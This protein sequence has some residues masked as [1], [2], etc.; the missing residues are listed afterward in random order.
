MSIRMSIRMSTRLQLCC[1]CG[2]KAFCSQRILWDQLVQAWQLAPEEAAYIDRQQGTVCTA[3]GCNL[4]AQALAK[5]ILSTRSRQPRSFRHLL[6]SPSFWLVK[7]L[8]L[9]PV[10]PLSSHLRRLPRRTLASYPEVDMQHLP[11]ADQTFDLVLHA[12]TLEH[13]PEPLAA[14]TECRRV[15]RPGGWCCFTIPMIVGRMTRSRTAY[16]PAIMGYQAMSSL[17][18]SCIRSMVRTAGLR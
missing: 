9:N 14:L 3:C 6:L 16:L 10:G 4:R 5:A 17:T 11:F 8:E 12:D 1:V 2:G 13:V 18:S 7:V 15:L